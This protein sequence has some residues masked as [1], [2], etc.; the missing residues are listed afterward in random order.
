M[1]GSNPVTPEYKSNIEYYQYGQ[2]A[3]IQHQEDTKRHP[4]MSPAKQE[5]MANIL[6]SDRMKQTLQYEDNY[7]SQ[8]LVSPKA[9]ADKTLM[10]S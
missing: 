8:S 10:F 5:R 1:M 7:V 3:K 4:Y 2:G 6:H 9:Q